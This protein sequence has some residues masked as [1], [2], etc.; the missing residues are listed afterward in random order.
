MVLFTN[1]HLKN[2]C[3]CGIMDWN[4]GRLFTAQ[5]LNIRKPNLCLFVYIDHVWLEKNL[6][7]AVVVDGKYYVSS[8]TVAT[9]EVVLRGSIFLVWPDDFQRCATF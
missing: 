3:G 5:S 1:D 4:C 2:I 6:V 8:P 7:V 9:I